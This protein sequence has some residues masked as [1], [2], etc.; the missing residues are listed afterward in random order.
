M[1]GVALRGPTN[2]EILCMIP[3]FQRARQGVVFGLEP[4]ACC[5]PSTIHRGPMASNV[6]IARVYES[7][8]LAFFVSKGTKEDVKLDIDASVCTTACMLDVAF[9][10][11]LRRNLRSTC[12]F[13]K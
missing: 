8:S 7:V 2:G 11:G 13:S 4:W 9:I 1:G 6:D 10:E 5:E 12:M 3:T